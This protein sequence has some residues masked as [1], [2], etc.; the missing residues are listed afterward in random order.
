MKDIVYRDPVAEEGSAGEVKSSKSGDGITLLASLISNVN[1]KQ[2]P[3]RSYFSS[4]PFEIAP[5]LVITVKGYIMTHRQKPARTCYI[6]L[7]GEKPQIATG[8]GQKTEEGT[9]REVEAKEIKKAYKFGGEY[10]YFSPEE[11]KLLKE[12]KMG[13]ERSSDDKG[14]RIIGFKPRSMLPLWASVKK[15][16]YIFPSEEDYVGSTRVFSALWQK[17]LK[18]KKMAVA[19]F[20]ARKNANPLLVAILPSQTQSEESGT[21][22]LPAGLWLY[23]LP[24]ADDLREIDRKR[25]QKCSDQLIDQMRPIV[26]NLQ[27]PKGTFNPAKYPNPSLQWHYKILQALALEEE[28]PE[29]GDDATVPKYKAINN[30]VG[31]YLVEFKEAVEGEAL[32]LQKTRAIKREAEADTDDRPKKRAKAAPATKSTG[33]GLSIAQLKAAV[34]KGTLGK[35]TVA[36]LKDILASKGVSTSGKKGDLVER[37]EQWVEANS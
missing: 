21:S 24:F 29:T 30:R 16:L 7:G 28:V 32:T 18:D 25:T 8:E 20:I 9:H 31:G 12:W 26:E 33:D 19:W 6:W 22:Y 13:P 2:T 23:P 15:A 34:D 10:V 27:L 37:L 3:K 36:E 35:K 4:L 1:S 17:L 14:L 5:G 11:H